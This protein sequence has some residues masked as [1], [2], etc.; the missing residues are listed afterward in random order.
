MFN[1]KQGYLKEFYDD[2]S[3]KVLCADEAKKEDLILEC[4]QEAYKKKFDG[5]MI[6]I[7]LEGVCGMADVPLSTALEKIKEYVSET[8]INPYDE[9]QNQSTSNSVDW[10]MEGNLFLSFL[11]EYY[12]IKKLIFW[13]A[14]HYVWNFNRYK[15]ISIDEIKSYITIYTQCKNLNLR[16]LKISLVQ[17]EI[18]RGVNSLT[19]LSKELDLP[20]QL[21]KSMSLRRPSITQQKVNCVSL[22]NGLVKI[23][24]L[25]VSGEIHLYPH[26]EN[27]FSITKLPYSFDPT[28]KS[29]MW[30][31]VLKEILDEDDRIDFVQE[32]FGYNL[33][34][35]CLY[36]KFLMLYGPGGAGKSVFLKVLCLMLGDGN[37]V[38]I[39]LENFDA[40]RS[41]GLAALDGMMANVINDSN[42]IDK[43]GEGIL[44]QFVAG[45]PITVERKYKDPFTMRSTAKLSIATNIEPRFSDKTDGIWRRLIYLVFRNQILDESKQNKN[46]MNDEWWIR[47]GELPGVFNWAL[48]GLI[49]L[50]QRGHFSIPASM[51]T[52]LMKYRDSNN[53]AAI[54]L[55]YNVE[56]CLPEERSSKYLPTHWLYRDFKVFCLANGYSPLN[57]HNFAKEVKRIF[58]NAAISE[59]SKY[60]LDPKGIDLLHV[61]SRWWIG[62]T[63]LTGPS[64][65][66]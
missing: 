10:V 32:W 63:G 22:D 66:D 2:W 30:L 61:K 3:I 40:K 14:D 15:K 26:D 49:R 53:A 64:V 11:K 28:A 41:F 46:L 5:G 24:E 19:F 65:G 7:M 18:I 8:R 47:S 42:E 38:S 59:E 52:D 34:S 56:E 1:E 57:S 20:F 50:E 58:P 31:K 25:L 54:F 48:E 33:V 39:G 36:Q 23:D 27:Y 45:E 9:K 6:R 4:I 44:K 55:K 43:P 62:I 16:H 12:G 37:F 17:E 51:Q 13:K 21:L 29:P 35:H 60:I